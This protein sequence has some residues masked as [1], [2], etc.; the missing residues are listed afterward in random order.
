MTAVDDA[1]LGVATEAGCCQ[2]CDLWQNATQTV[3]GE[4]RGAARV[5]LVGEQPGDQEDLAGHP[6]VGPAG[7]LLDQAIADAGLERTA[8]YL[9]NAVKHFKWKPRSK[10]RIHERPNRAEVT[11]CNHWLKEEIMLL[12]PTV[13]VALGATAGQALFGPSF[14]VGATRGK[15]LEYEGLSVVATGHPSAIL[16]IPSGPER[17]TAYQALVGDLHRAAGMAEG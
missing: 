16:R 17:E 7:G 8:L 13:I 4:G 5:M 2:R 3:F 12:R 11:A 9:T 10:R 14:R 6:F 15:T 1:L